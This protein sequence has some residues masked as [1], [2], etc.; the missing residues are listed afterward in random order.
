MSKD[1][2]EKR[3]KRIELKDCTAKA[4]EVAVDFMY[5]ISIPKNFTELRELLHIAD[6]FMMEN[7]TEVVV[8]LYEVTKENYLEVSQAADVY[9]VDSLVTKCA[10]FV[11]E[12]MG[13]ELEWQEI[14]KLSTVMAAFGERSK[15]K[16]CW[17]NLKAVKRSL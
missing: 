11:Y 10:D 12:N 16:N 13:E 8:K 4:L 1:W 15:G 17:V 14:G 3:E 7:L 2:M 9:N 5:G 6:L